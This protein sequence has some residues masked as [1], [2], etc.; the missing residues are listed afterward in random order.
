LKV[1]SLTS[2]FATEFFSLRRPTRFDSFDRP[3]LFT[4]HYR[5]RRA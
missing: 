3:G 5:T 4:P 1:I 2:I